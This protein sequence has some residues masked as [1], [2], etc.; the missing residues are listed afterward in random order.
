MIKKQKEDNLRSK[1]E[2]LIVLSREGFQQLI[3]SIEHQAKW[4]QYFNDEPELA[5]V[6]QKSIDFSKRALMKFFDE[7]TE[8]R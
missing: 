7:I 8:E 2:V 3:N 1:G 5:E 4:V 6:S